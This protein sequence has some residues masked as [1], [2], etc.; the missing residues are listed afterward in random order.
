MRLVFMVIKT[1]KE[2][3]EPKQSNEK[4]YHSRDL[5]ILKDWLSFENNIQHDFTIANVYEV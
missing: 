2:L 3:F 4:G 1:F 5:Q